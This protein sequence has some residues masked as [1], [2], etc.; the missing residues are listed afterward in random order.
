[1]DTNVIVS[2][3]VFGGVPRQVLDL[4]VTGV[5]SFY[6]S[7]PI[8]VEV[9]RIL[10]EK[11]GWSSEEIHIRTRTLW[12]LGTQV[13]PEV[14]L[15]VVTDDPDDDRILECAV[16]AEADAII[17]GD[18]HLLRLGSFQLIPIQSPRQFLDRKAWETTP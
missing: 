6:L 8:Q 5:R 1:M 15:A 17:S 16:A 3:L 14:S 12:N 18:R 13:K 4:A 7:A 2:A 11:F 9:E 10:E